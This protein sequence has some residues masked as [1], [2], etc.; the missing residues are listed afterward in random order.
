MFL[1]KRLQTPV[2]AIRNDGKFGET[3]EVMLYEELCGTGV[4]VESR[5]EAIT[6][7]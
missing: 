3:P 7:L 6:N 2:S 4:W 5:E 1:R